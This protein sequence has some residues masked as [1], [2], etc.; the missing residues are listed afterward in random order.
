VIPT[1]PLR[2][3][4]ITAGLLA[5]FLS[6][7]DT[8]ILSTAMPTIVVE[9]GGLSLYSWVFAIYMVMT[10]ISLPIWGKLADS[11]RKEGLFEAAVLIFLS[12]SVLCGFSRS[13]D[14]L[15]LFRGLQGIGAGGLASIPFA[16]ISL[17]YPPHERGKALGILSSA[18]GISSVIGPALG[19][20]IVSVLSWPWVFFLN[21]PLG[22]AAI[23]LVA[24]SHAE[25]PTGKKE[26]VD[27]G[28]ALL[29]GGLILSLLLTARSVS[30]AE[31]AWG[32]AVQGTVVVS[33]LAAFLAQER[34]A[35]NP[36]LPLRYF[37]Q[38]SFWLGN[39]LGFLSSFS[40]YAIVAFLPLYA[41]N[42][43][44]GTAVQSGLVVAP[45][46]LAWSLSSIIAGRWVSR[47]GENALIRGGMFCLMAGLMLLLITDQNTALW[48]I[49]ACGVIAG[50]G[51]GCLT[52]PLLLSVQHSL[53]AG[54]VGVATS[55]QML[56]RTIGGAIG[57]SVLGAVLTGS[58]VA[59]LTAGLG[60]GAMPDLPRELVSLLLDPQKL[61]AP[62]V[63]S[64]LSRE[65]LTF[66]LT[67]FV[68]GLHRAFLGGLF[69]VVCG[70][71]GCRF[72]PASSLHIPPPG[73][74]TPRRNQRH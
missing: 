7:L 21:L 28:G 49:I 34:R 13:M 23:A 72:L 56:A 39:L 29:L 22:A 33:F 58:I 57:V 2:L 8:T 64:Q 30:Q 38:R 42:V 31:H 10:A 25:S 20:A 46:S 11:R 53:S 55:A 32:V 36:I 16:M 71:V 69:V 61:L 26:S 19:S 44:G 45:M 9:L 41:Q 50:T 15:I 52:P 4:T 65:Q 12:G 6:A 37:S 18:W 59:D 35:K 67:S 17:Y 27:Y 24:V 60:R 3:R 68:H 51:M 62:E 5:A 40:M 1:A 73:I 43:L 54:E 74:P 48:Y 66:V 63:R 47:L 14:L 70:F